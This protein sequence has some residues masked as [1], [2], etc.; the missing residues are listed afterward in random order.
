VLVDGYIRDVE[1]LDSQSLP[2]WAMGAS[3]LSARYRMETVEINGPITFAGMAVRPGDVVVA[4]Q[5]GIAV[6]PREQLRAVVD[7]CEQQAIQA[8]PLSAAIAEA[9]S[10]PDLISSV[11][12]ATG[13][14]T[15]NR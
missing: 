6:V 10:L 3:P 1:A 8:R 11:R 14:A 12:G 9:N 13:S 7:V 5:N 4:D 15:G 2:V